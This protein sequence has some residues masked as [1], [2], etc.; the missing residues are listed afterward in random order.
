MSDLLGLHEERPTSGSSD[1][2]NVASGPDPEWAAR[3]K[4]GANWFYWIAALSTINSVAFLVGAKFHFL[5]G[6]GL[7][8][9]A[10]AVVDVSIQQGASAAIKAV[11]IVFDLIVVIGFGLAGYFANKFFRSVFLIGIIVYAVDAVIVLLLGDF[12]MAAFHAFAL[13]SLIR[14]YL[15]CRELKAHQVR[16]SAIVPVAPADAPPPPPVFP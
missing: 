13:Y 1:Y 4:R 5:A 3:V 6:L 14:G 2:E 7:T 10:D 11:S 12:F 8:E 9:I 15:A 16:T